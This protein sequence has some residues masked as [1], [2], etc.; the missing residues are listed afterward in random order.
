MTLVEG[1]S[2]VEQ[3]EQALAPAAAS[4]LLRRRLLVLDLDVEAIGEPFDCTGEVELLR[5]AHKRDDVALRAA[6]EAVVELPHGVDGEARRALLVER[7]PSDIA[8]AGL[9][10]LRAAADHGDDVGRG[11]D[12]LDGRILD[13]GH[14]PSSATYVSAK[15]S[16]IPAMKSTICSGSSPPATRWSTIRRIAARAR[17]CSS[18]A[19]GPR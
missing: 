9:S 2:G 14:Q 12:V 11:L 15:R 18:R 7:A 1:R 10:Q 13:A 16:V 3:L 17:S 8:R 4:I 6:A 5:L 19:C